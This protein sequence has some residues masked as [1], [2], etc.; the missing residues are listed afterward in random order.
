[1]SVKI[2]VT[3]TNPQ[4]KFAIFFLKTGF[5]AFEAEFDPDNPEIIL[6]SVTEPGAVAVY[7]ASEPDVIRA[8]FALPLRHAEIVNAI[9]KLRFEEK[10]NAG[11][12]IRFG[13]ITLHPDDQILKHETKDTLIALTDG[14]AELC[15]FLMKRPDGA[16]KAEC[17]EK[18]NRFGERGFESALYRLRKKLSELGHTVALKNECYILEPEVRK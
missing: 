16:D 4:D 18:F 3:F 17:A 9:K 14:E 13:G 10:R 5:D 7:R 1:M 6:D 8:R 12:E 11:A 15:A 2:K